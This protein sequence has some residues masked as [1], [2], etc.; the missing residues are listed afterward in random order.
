MSY[1]YQ[2]TLKRGRSKPLWIGHPWVFSGAIHT[3]SGPKSG[4]GGPCLVADERGNVLGAGFYNPDARIA[5]RLYDH[6]RSTDIPFEPTPL[7]D[8]LEARITAALRRRATLGLGADP[9]TTAYRLVNSEGDG[10]S[11]LV[12]DRFADT[13]SVQLNARSMYE[14]RAALGP[15]LARLTGAQRVVARVTDEA[16]KREGIPVET[17]VLVGSGAGEAAIEVE[18]LEGGVRYGV[19]VGAG[20]KTGFYCDQRDNRARFAA[21]CAGQR[22][23]D[24]Y[25]YVGGFG[26][27]ALKAGAASVEAVD[28]SRPA[29][30]RALDNAKRNGVADRYS[31][32]TE[33]AMSFLK[34]A[35]AQGR[36]WDRVVCDPPKFAHGRAGHDDALKKYA[37]LN[38]LA[39]GV[40]APGGAMLTCSCSQHVT[41]DELLRVLTD[42]GHRLRRAVHVHAVWS[43]GPDHP[44][45]SVAAQGK[46]LKAVLLTVEDD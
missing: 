44:W 11:G 29:V 43:Q 32:V 3:V 45:L 20:Q 36:T 21:L 34:A 1:P 15:L 18:I 2:V 27:A 41:E 19:P 33:D 12:V 42:A 24:L 26:L 40:L 16:S 31:A 22:V 10:L 14:Q 37:R 38:T 8:L 6:R 17:E 7:A 28:S 9:Q 35:H 13:L 4:R 46:Y 23:L 39:M 5:V 25:S 30:E